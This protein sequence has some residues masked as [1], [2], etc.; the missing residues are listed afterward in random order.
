MERTVADS[1]QPSAIGEDAGVRDFRKMRVWEKAHLL[2]IRIYKA[3]ASFP[4]TEL[5]GLTSQMR[6]AATS[7]PANIAEGCGRSGE[8]DFARF[9]TIAMG[10][11]TETEYFILLSR[12]LGYLNMATAGELTDTTQAVKKMLATLLKRIRASH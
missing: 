8:A 12:D 3:T 4:K 9:L 7:V 2:A 10:S 11:A 6:R 5:Y 1:Y